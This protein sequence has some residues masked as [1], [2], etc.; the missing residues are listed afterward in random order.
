[1]GTDTEVCGSMTTREYENDVPIDDNLVVLDLL[2]SDRWEWKIDRRLHLPYLNWHHNKGK[3]YVRVAW[4]EYHVWDFLVTPGVGERLFAQY[5]VEGKKHWGFTDERDL[6][7]TD[8]GRT[9][10][11]DAYERAGVKYDDNFTR[12]LRSERWIIETR[13]AS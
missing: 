13:I 9:L 6:T 2:Y 12:R 1:M 4:S 11:R 10:V 5:L 3:P 7:I 8:H